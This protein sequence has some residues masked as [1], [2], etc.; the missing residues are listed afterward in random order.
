MYGQIANRIWRYS[1]MAGITVAVFYG[2]IYEVLDGSLRIN[3]RDWLPTKEKNYKR[4]NKMA[5]KRMFFKKKMAALLMSCVLS[6]MFATLSF[7]E[8]IIIDHTCTDLSK[9]P[10]YWLEQAKQLA[11]HYAHTSHGSQVT[12]G[13]LNLESQD[14]EYSVA[15]RT[16]TSEGL[17]PVED[18][19][20]FRMYDGN[21]PETYISPNDYWDGEAGKNRTRT[22]ADTGNYGF[23][24]WSWCGQVSGASESYIQNYL[25]S[26]NLFESEYPDMR[27]IYMTGH[28]DGTNSTGNLHLRNEQIRAYCLA[29]DKVLF[30][31][32]DIERYDPG[33][34]DYLDQGANDNCD[35][36]GG[37]WANEWC[38]AHP[39]SDLCA[40]CSCA[41]S[42][43]L[44]CNV[45]ARAFWWMLARLAGWDPNSSTSASVTLVPDSVSLSR[46]DTL[47]C[48]VTVSNNIDAEQTVYFGTNVTLPDGDFYPD[49]T[50]LVGPVQVVLE[51]AGSESGH[52]SHFIP[53]DA[54][55]GSYTYYGYIGNVEDGIIDQDFFDFTVTE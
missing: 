41:H 30:D 33:G 50:Y 14:A 1:E 18:P 28:L 51:P 32:A 17:P 10:A 39:D 9:I 15:I 31:F 3:I 6:A 42:Q 34:S 44:N 13:I 20:A 36:N 19:P 40:S 53:G 24:M 27:F 5:G 55:L 54:P 26:M 7:A 47:G 4:R 12:S 22:V 48:D 8:P 37:N 38:A 16:S 29:N 2:L 45:K 46:G 25:D 35:Y 11:F 49:S 21:P 43:S 23:S 52:L